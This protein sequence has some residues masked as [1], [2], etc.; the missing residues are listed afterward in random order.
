MAK[1]N[2]LQ[3]SFGL[4]YRAIKCPEYRLYCINILIIQLRILTLFPNNSSRK[5]NLTW[6][7][8]N[9]ALRDRINFPSDKELL[10]AESHSNS[11]QNK[12]S[13]RFYPRKVKMQH[14]PP[15]HEVEHEATDRISQITSKKGKPPLGVIGEVRLT[16]A[17]S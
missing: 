5:V 16:E 11:K 8:V 9:K 1:D 3:C 14:V 10:K 6:L 15:S 7:I 12:K 4:A 13:I 2:N 17:I